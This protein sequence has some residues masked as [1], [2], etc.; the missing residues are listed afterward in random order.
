MEKKTVKLIDIIVPAYNEEESLPLFYEA[1]KA[2]ESGLPGYG[3]RYIFVDDGSI[4]GSLEI[5]KDMAAKD[6]EVKYISFSRNFG[7]EAAI[8]AGLRNSSGDMVVLIDADLQH[9]TQLIPDMI[10]AV[11]NEGYG[12][13]GAKRK[14]GFFSRSFTALNNSI[15]KTKLEKGATDFM[16]MSRAFVD[17][18]LQLSETRRFTK[19]LFAWV[20]FKIK[21]LDFV[22]SKRAA[23]KSKWTFKKL[24]SYATDGLTAFSTI[25]LRL[26]T[27]VGA[28]VFILAVIYIIITL[29]QTIIWGIDVPGYVT[30]LVVL[31]F[32]G[33]VIMLAIGILGEYISSI[34]M[35]TKNRPIYIMEQT[36]I[37]KTVSN[38]DKQICTGRTEPAREEDK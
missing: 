14:A 29:I 22:Q 4:D 12:A 24:F 5:M 11:E 33:G 1:I 9:P 37:G 31:L 8:Y 18:V 21:W 32:M 27:I 7:K 17:A 6:P 23:G 28:L 34:Y 13:A 19:G 26:V 20:G 36:N 25:P 30:T 38:E 10:N 16:C 2:V 15:S 35:E 3:F